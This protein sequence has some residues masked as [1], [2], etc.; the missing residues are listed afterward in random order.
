MCNVDI[1]SYPEIK[2]KYQWDGNGED[3]GSLKN[4]MNC[5]IVKFNKSCK[6]G[7][8]PI[9][10]DPDKNYHFDKLI[11]KGN[12]FYSIQSQKYNIDI[13]K[14]K[15]MTRVKMVD[16]DSEVIVQDQMQFRSGKSSYMDELNQF[17]I[18]KLYI[19]KKAKLLYTKGSIQDNGDIK[20]FA[21]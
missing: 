12:K 7:V 15:G 4:E 1:H 19:T 3:L 11:I 17:K 13:S 6:E 20:P 16:F 8:T 2:Q 21:L 10:Y 14:C 9:E 5:K 18:T